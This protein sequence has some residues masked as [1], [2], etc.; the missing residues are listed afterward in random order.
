MRLFDIAYARSGDKGDSANI[1]VAARHARDY[2]RLR[3]LL[4][5]Q[6]I[7]EYFRD[8][9]PG[10]VERYELPN[11][12]ALNFVLHGVLDG[13]ATRSLRLDPQGKTLCDALMMMEIADG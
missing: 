9:C 2:N 13:G 3:T 11:L 6:L 8:I 7:Q 1:G 10:P 4:T 12:N 5:T